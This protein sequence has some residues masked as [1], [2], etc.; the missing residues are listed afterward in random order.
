[1][2]S[3]LNAL[4]EVT[5]DRLFQRLHISSNSE[6][7][8][9]LGRTEMPLHANGSEGDIHLLAAKRNVSG[10]TRR[11]DGRDCRDAFLGLMRTAGMRGIAFWDYL[12]NGLSVPHRCANPFLPNLT[13]CRG[14][15][16]PDQNRQGCC[17]CYITG[18]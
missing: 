16:A 15:S 6:L 11:V 14:N 9:A 7:L 13:R 4:L 18:C 12:G 10:G 3:Y 17:R 2:Q 5:L 1:M 8:T